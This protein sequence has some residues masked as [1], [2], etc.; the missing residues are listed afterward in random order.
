VTTATRAKPAATARTPK[1]P[2][3]IRRAVHRKRARVA[4]EAIPYAASF[5]A[6]AAGATILHQPDLG[7]VAFGVTS[8]VAGV[9]LHEAL[10]WHRS[11]GKAAMRKR[12]RYQGTASR[13]ELRRKLSVHAAG[14]HAR[15][16]GLDLGAAAAAVPLGRAL[17]QDVAGT[18]ADS[19]LVIAPPQMLKTALIAG[20]AMNAPG[21]LLATSSRIDLY[22][23]TAAAREATGPVWVLNP[24]GDGDIPST[25]EWSP[26]DGCQD[27]RAAIRRAGAL[28]AAAPSDKSGKDAYW[29][30]KGADLL[31]LMLHAAALAG[32]TMLEVRT[33]VNSPESPAPAAI[34][35]GEYAEPGWAEELEALCANQEQL[36]HVVS[37]AAGALRWM[38]DPAMRKAACPS[39]D[40]F[41][42]RAFAGDGNGTVYLIGADAEHGTVAPYFAAFAAEM[43]EQLKQAAARNGGRLGRPAT[44]ALDEAAT[45]VPV[46][47]HKWTSVAAGYNITVIAG[48]QALS[49][50][51][52]RWGEHDARTIRTN[53]TVKVIGGGFT[54]DAELEALSAVCGMRDTWDH[55][56]HPDGS[57]TKTPRQERLFPPERIRMLDQW[58]LLVVHRNTRPV[59]T[60]ITPVWDLPGYRRADLPGQEFP[61]QMAQAQPA[62]AAPRREAIPVPAGLAGLSASTDVPALTEAKE[63]AGCP[64]SYVPSA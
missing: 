4:R 30:A 14:R 11:G 21:A 61:G 60:V 41:D 15:R 49:Q 8:G 56:R 46:P 36:G 13:A 64:A 59:E 40:G 43:F 33:W 51:P 47:L 38:N 10:G 39:G 44:L 29:D 9:R 55:T 12:R 23:H 34:L 16:T 5:A 2:G 35:A 54:D 22:L 37:G 31:R 27:P 17:G 57:R 1:P 3:R 24:D 48:I 32:A 53:F 45:I 19:Y 52:A 26:L 63:D 42:C 58:H 20:W 25:L 62:I 28:M 6:A 50:L 18:R 7:L